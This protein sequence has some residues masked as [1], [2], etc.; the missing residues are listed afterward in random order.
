M[1]EVEHVKWSEVVLIRDRLRA[2]GYIVRSA[3]ASL[4]GCDDEEP[5]LREGDKEM[6][7]GVG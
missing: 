2:C 5:Q 4:V 1:N 7:P 6:P 3:I